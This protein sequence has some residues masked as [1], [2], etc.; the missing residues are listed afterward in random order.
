MDPL[1]YLKEIVD[2]VEWNG[3]TFDFYAT[4]DGSFDEK[5]SQLILRL[6]CF[7]VNVRPT[8]LIFVVDDPTAQESAA[9][10][11]EF[12]E[13]A[14]DYLLVESPAKLQR[15]WCEFSFRFPW[16]SKDCGI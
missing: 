7:A 8:L 12:F 10:S 14:A 2:Q 5:K 1:I 16:P 15:A 11:I 9:N 3:T 13:D 4:A 6:D